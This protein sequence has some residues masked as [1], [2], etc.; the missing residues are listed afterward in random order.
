MRQFDVVETPAEP[1]SNVEDQTSAMCL[2]Q[3]QDA[4]L[5]TVRWE[6]ETP[7]R[8]RY[9]SYDPDAHEL[10]RLF[11]RAGADQINGG[12]GPATSGSPDRTLELDRN[13]NFVS[14]KAVKHHLAGCALAEFV[15]DDWAE[16]TVK[17]MKG[18]LELL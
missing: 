7:S 18:R 13:V 12:G 17:K 4:S 5:L 10:V 6:T 9:A 2:Q 15:G 14:R 3:M 1:A 16:L 8:S 11:V